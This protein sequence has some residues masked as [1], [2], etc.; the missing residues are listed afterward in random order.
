MSRAT[1]NEVARDRFSLKHPEDVRP[2]QHPGLSPEKVTV[3]FLVSRAVTKD[4]SVI[5]KPP[6]VW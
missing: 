3:D 5:L 6:R 1:R 4:V 2:F